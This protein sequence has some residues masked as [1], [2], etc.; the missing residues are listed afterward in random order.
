MQKQFETEH[1]I[2]H[3]HENSE[4]EKDILKI[5][6]TQEAVFAQMTTELGVSFPTKILYY[7]CRS[8]EEVGQ[9]YGDNEPCNGFT[10]YPNT[11]YAVYNENIHCIGPHEDTH[12]ISYQI[13]RPHCVFLREGLAMKADKTWWGIPNAAWCRYFLEHDLYLSIKDLFA[14]DFFYAQGCEVSYPIAG[15]F[16]DWLMSTYTKETFLRLYKAEQDHLPELER[17]L[18]KSVE[19]IEAEFLSYVHAQPYSDETQNRIEAEIRRG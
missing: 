19:E 9:I 14:D 5:S 1:Y 8:P 16:V 2:F 7:L 6:E 4:A 3:Y 12:I 15:A 13:N 10:R 11:I 17:L 18:G